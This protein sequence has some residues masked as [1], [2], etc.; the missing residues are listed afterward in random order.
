MRSS[1]DN[2]PQS[3]VLDD[4]ELKEALDEAEQQEAKISNT[5]SKE[6]TGKAEQQEASNTPSKESLSLHTGTCVISLLMFPR[7][8]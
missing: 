8:Q 1:K 2:N 7:D 5:P 4:V 3:V 6:Y